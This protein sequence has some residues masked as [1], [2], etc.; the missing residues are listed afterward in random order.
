M[1]IK[2]VNAVSDFEREPLLRPFGF[3]GSAIHEIWQTA[4][5]LES[6][7]GKSAVGLCS[8]NVLWADSSVFNGFSE[9]AA[10][11]VMYAV[12]DYAVQ[13]VCGISFETPID[14]SDAIIDDV[15]DYARK[16]TGNANLKKTFVLNALV[17]LDHAAW[18][19][20]AAENDLDFDG[21]IPN[22]FRAPLRAHQ[23]KIAA[24]PLI[25]YGMTEAEIIRLVNDGSFFL[26]IKLGQPGSQQEMAA[27]DQ[28]RLVQIHRLIG[29]YETPYTRSGKLLYYLDANGRYQSKETLLQLFE[30]ADSIGALEQIALVE[31]PFP[32]EIEITVQDLPVRLAADESAHTAHDAL[33]RIEMGYRAIALKPAAKTLSMSLRIAK[34]AYV[35]NVPCFCADLTVNPIL[36]DW[37]KNIAARLEA[38]PNWSMS[39]CWR[40]TDGRTTAIGSGSCRI[41]R[42]AAL[43]GLNRRAVFIGSM[44]VFIDKTAASL[45]LRLIMNRWCK[46]RLKSEEQTAG[47][48]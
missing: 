30:L 35:H 18:L 27:K 24:V 5:R 25:S 32:E 3:K 46:K 29:S 33:R 39:G 36:V 2:I 12:T 21:M 31:E 20:Y 6:N 10:N 38:F 37:N 28:N 47:T 4:V 8:Q 44:I 17:A 40:V 14:L 23:D 26:K 45:L 43:H 13:H 16:I 1:A 9:S 15:T 22:E 41:I 34:T 48:V 19:L 42:P 7:T 11:A